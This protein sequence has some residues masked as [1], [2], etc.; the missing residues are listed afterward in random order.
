MEVLCEEI[1]GW[2]LTHEYCK[3]FFHIFVIFMSRIGRKILEKLEQHR[4]SVEKKL[5]KKIFT[6]SL[7]TCFV[8]L[9]HNILA[10]TTWTQWTLIAKEKEIWRQILILFF[11]LWAVVSIKISLIVKRMKKTLLWKLIWKWLSLMEMEK[12]D[13]KIS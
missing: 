9:F 12:K 13:E 4:N 5:A 8:L 7:Q 2:H 11:A 6:T 1:N 3:S 10:I